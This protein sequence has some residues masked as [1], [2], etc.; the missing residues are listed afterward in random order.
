M[1]GLYGRF[2]SDFR[3]EP[4]VLGVT[5]EYS[6]PVCYHDIH[7]GTVIMGKCLGDAEGAKIYKF[8][9][10]D[11][12][13]QIALKKIGSLLAHDNVSTQLL[14]W[15]ESDPIPMRLDSGEPGTL[16]LVHVPVVQLRP[17]RIIY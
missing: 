11:K 4:K 5:T 8:D 1:A 3:H 6:F 12:D 17:V 14:P 9:N 13:Q 7:S 16:T 10:L 2:E 15:F